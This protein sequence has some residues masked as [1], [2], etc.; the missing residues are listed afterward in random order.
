MGTPGASS[1]WI[2]VGQSCSAKVSRPTIFGALRAL[3]KAWTSIPFAAASST[4]VGSAAM[5]MPRPMTAMRLAL[6]GSVKPRPSGP[7]TSQRP[8]AGMVVI[9]RRVP[10]PSTL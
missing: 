9:I 8:P 7:M 10:S 3:R 2:V 6:G 5:P 4:N 1:V